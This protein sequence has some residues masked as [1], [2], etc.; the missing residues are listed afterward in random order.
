VEPLLRSD[1][2]FL[3][4]KDFHEKEQ[5]F[6][7]HLADLA[8]RALRKAQD[9]R[10]AAQTQFLEYLRTVQSLGRRSTWLDCLKWINKTNDARASLLRPHESPDRELSRGQFLAR[11]R[12]LDEEVETREKRQGDRQVEQYRAV[13]SKLLSSGLLSPS[14]RWRHFSPVASSLVALGEEDGRAVAAV[15]AMEGEVARDVFEDVIDRIAAE[16]REFKEEV[17]RGRKKEI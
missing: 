11:A 16:Y 5:L 7:Q 12:E 13:L 9:E 15:A 1:P 17:R 4:I 14:S 10:S 8:G 6:R 2:R 3:L